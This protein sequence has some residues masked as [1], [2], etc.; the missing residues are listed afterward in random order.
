MSIHYK[1]LARKNPQDPNAPEKY[2]GQAVITSKMDLDALAQR[3]A[4]NTTLGVGDIFGVLKS[5][6][7][8]IINALTDGMA[9]ELGGICDIYPQVSGPGAD[10][11]EDFSA[12][13]NVTRKRVR[14]RSKAKL[15]R[16]ME[17]VALIRRES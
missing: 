10:T 13:V 16:S 4:Q 6:E 2:Y 7:E 9:V 3:I 14:I 1:V 15:N 5:L 8:A 12:A 11:L 17:T